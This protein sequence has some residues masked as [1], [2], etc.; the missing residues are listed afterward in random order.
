[1]T[2]YVKISRKLT[3]WSWY[4]DLNTCKLFLHMIL[5]ANWKDG[6]YQG[7]ETPRGTFASSYT[8]LAQETGLSVKNVRTA[9]K[10]LENTGEVAVNRQAKFSI[11]TVK[12]YDVYQTGGRQVAENRQATGNNNRRREEVKNKRNIYACACACARKG[13]STGFTNFQE[14]EYNFDVLEDLILQTQ[15]ERSSYEN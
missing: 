11:F 8:E 13:Q 2:G 7:V 9:L 10:H 12:N 5:K 1:M 6:E 4:K 15:E 3:Q 14:R